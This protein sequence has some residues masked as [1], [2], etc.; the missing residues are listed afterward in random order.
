MSVPSASGTIPAATAAAEPPL[1]PPGMRSGRAGSGFR[2][3]R[4]VLRGHAPGELVGARAAD[5]HRTGRPHRAPP[6]RRAAPADRPAPPDRRGSTAPATSNR[7]LT[8]TGTPSSG[9]AGLPAAARAVP[10]LG[11]ATGTLGV[12]LDERRRHAVDLGDPG[13]RRLDHLDGE[14]AAP[15]RTAAT[16]VDRPARRPATRRATPLR[17]CAPEL[18]LDDLAGVVAGQRVEEVHVARHLV[19]GELALDPVLDGLA[20]R[21]TPASRST[22]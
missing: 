16:S 18:P 8:A 10:P 9:P 2:R 6:S 17:S 13:Q 11:R 4:R 15:A 22:T 14:P 5:E 19:A 20:R 12:H 1:E 3:A 7:S 21:A